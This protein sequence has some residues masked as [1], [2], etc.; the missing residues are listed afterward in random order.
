MESK[1]LEVGDKIHRLY[2]KKFEKEYTIIKVT[3]TQAIAENG[4]R[5][6]RDVKND[7]WIQRYGEKPIFSVQYKLIEGN[8]F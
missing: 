5:F 1:I 7:W 4:V 6:M 3:K 8:P 2:L